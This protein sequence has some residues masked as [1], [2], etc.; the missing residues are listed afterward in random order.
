[1]YFF[2][3][4]GYFEKPAAGDIKDAFN[5]VYGYAATE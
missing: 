3:A 4:R 1:M 2:K 5:S